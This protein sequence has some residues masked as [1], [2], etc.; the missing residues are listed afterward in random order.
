MFNSIIFVVEKKKSKSIMSD[1]TFYKIK[2]AAIESETAQASTIT[3]DIPDDQKELF[4][5]V[6]GQ[7]LTLKFEINGKELRRA[8][9]LCSSPFFDIKPM[10]GVKRVKNGVVS[11]HINDNLQVGQEVEVMPP[12]G[13][14]TTGRFNS[15][16]QNRGFKSN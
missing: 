4:K 16:S 13:N 1:T 14:F 12:Q 6:H 5:Y 8:Y 2:V 10:I 7:Y 9:S 15:F 3:F 11:N